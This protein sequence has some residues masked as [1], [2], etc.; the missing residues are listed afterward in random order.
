LDGFRLDGQPAAKERISKKRYGFS[1]T[2]V[3][4]PTAA[5]PCEFPMH[6]TSCQS[7]L[8]CLQYAL[9]AVA[10]YSHEYSCVLRQG[11]RYGC[12]QNGTTRSP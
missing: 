1:V 10:L 5:A 6:E 8:S 3:S 9:A 4:T 7:D 11:L 2:Y 12:N